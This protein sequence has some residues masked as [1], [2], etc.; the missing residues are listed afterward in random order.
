MGVKISK[1]KKKELA[2]DES[3][4]GQSNMAAGNSCGHE[5]RKD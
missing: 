2:Q 3:G 5:K 4:R 1:K